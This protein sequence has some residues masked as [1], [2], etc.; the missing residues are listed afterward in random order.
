MDYNYI[1]QFKKF[2]FG[3]CEDCWNKKLQWLKNNQKNTR[4]IVSQRKRI[5]EHR[6]IKN[7]PTVERKKERKKERK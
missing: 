2:S 3:I 4:Q 7:E 5:S 1:T 6:E